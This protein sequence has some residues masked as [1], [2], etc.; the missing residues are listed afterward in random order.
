[1]DFK[2]MI[3]NLIFGFF[4]FFFLYIFF[5]NS[6]LVFCQSFLF[7]CHFP[8]FLKT[9]GQFYEKVDRYQFFKVFFTENYP[10]HTVIYRRIYIFFT[11]IYTGFIWS[12]Y[13]QFLYTGFI[14]RSLTNVLYMK[15]TLPVFS[16]VLIWSFLHRRFYIGVF[17]WSSHL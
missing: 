17:S 7:F 9:P 5:K 10:V 11:C 1:M 13:W 3:L 16:G 12:F 4:V 8:G 14:C 15:K 6:G 2:K